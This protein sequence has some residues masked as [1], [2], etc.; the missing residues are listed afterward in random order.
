M[1]LVAPILRDSS[2]HREYSRFSIAA[3]SLAPCWCKLALTGKWRLP[4]AQLQSGQMN[5]AAFALAAF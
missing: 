3:T 4:A 2:G 5:A 1:M